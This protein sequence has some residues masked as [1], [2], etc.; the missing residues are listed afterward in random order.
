MSEARK[1]SCVGNQNRREESH[2]AEDKSMSALRQYLCS[3]ARPY[4]TGDVNIKACRNCESPCAFGKRYLKLYDAGETP[5]KRKATNTKKKK[6][7]AREAETEAH[8]VNNAQDY[9]RTLLEDEIE[10]LRGELAKK[11]EQLGKLERKI[12]LTD[13]LVAELKKAEETARTEAEQAKAARAQLEADAQAATDERAQ[14]YSKLEQER[15]LCE[16]LREDN[17][18]MMR[19]VCEQA[20]ELQAA[21][22]GEEKALKEAR[23]LMEQLTAL[24]VWMLEQLHPELNEI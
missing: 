13:V 6:P 18:Q 1:F 23:R 9:E 8:P 5:V 4:R 21:Q 19:S 15:K 3:M 22:N 7:A 12:K 11:T 14:L 20:A 16:K 24:K 17:E 2:F 10:Q